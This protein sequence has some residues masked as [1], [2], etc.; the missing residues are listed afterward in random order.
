[1]D[2]LT[3][4]LSS[5][6]RAAIFRNLFG[7][8]A[9]EL[10]MR[11][12]QRVAGCTIGPIQVELKKLLASQLVKVRRNSNRLYYQANQEHPLYPDI[13]S[14]VLKTS[15]LGDYLKE[16][17]SGRKDIETAFIFGSM[18]SGEDTPASDIDLMVIGTIGLRALST[19][20][21]DFRTR[22]GREL[23]PHVLTQEEFMK[24]RKDREHFITNVISSSRMFVK[25]TDDD[26]T[27][28]G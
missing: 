13:R 9:V 10:H 28:M 25:G 15:G 18:A 24:R 2:I 21:S 7:V 27:Q 3:Q 26:F 8:N 19:V 5:K 17:F 4:I 14:M 23:N 16:L 12:I 22:V 6:V 11:E 20:L 1:M